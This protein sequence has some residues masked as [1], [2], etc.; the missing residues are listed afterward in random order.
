[1]LFEIFDDLFADHLALKAAQGAL[2]RFVRIN[3]N[4]SH[5]FTHLLSAGIY[6]EFTL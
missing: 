1:M 2:D 4:K 3:C 5:I 6:S